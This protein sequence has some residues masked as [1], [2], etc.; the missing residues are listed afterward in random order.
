M[1]TPPK[2]GLRPVEPARRIDHIQRSLR[3]LLAGVHANVP[4]EKCMWRRRLIRVF[5]WRMF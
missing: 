2:S 4:S 3:L 5:S 1:I